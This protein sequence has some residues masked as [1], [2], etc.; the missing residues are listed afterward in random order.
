MSIKECQRINKFENKKYSI[1]TYYKNKQLN[2]IQAERIKNTSI[3]MSLTTG[4]K[5][6]SLQRRKQITR[7]SHV[8]NEKIETIGTHRLFV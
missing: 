3:L 5:Y 8:N 2:S 1:R 7:I 4:K 6:T